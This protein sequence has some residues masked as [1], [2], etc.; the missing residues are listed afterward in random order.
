[1]AGFTHDVLMS[2]IQL[3]HSHNF[4]NDIYNIDKKDDDKI[5]WVDSV[6]KHNNIFLK[7]KKATH[8]WFTRF[9]YEYRKS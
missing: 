6:V 9:T 8:C 4:F 2:H 3:P 5:D 1:M 7:K